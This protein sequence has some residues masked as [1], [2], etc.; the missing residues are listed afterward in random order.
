MSSGALE[1]LSGGSWMMRTGTVSSH[2]G[3]AAAGLDG[4]IYVA[5]NDNTWIYTVVSD[6]WLVSYTPATP[7][8]DTAVALGSDR[9]V[10]VIGGEDGVSYAVDL[11]DAWQPATSMWLP[12]APLT[13]A[14]T[15]SAAVTA[16][17]GRIY[18]IG[19][20]QLDVTTTNT[21]ECYTPELDHWVMIAPLAVKRVGAGAALGSDGRIYAIGGANPN[22]TPLRSVE[23]YG[24][25]ATLTPATAAASATVTLTGDNFAASAAVAITFDGTPVASGVT[26]DRGH[27]VTEILVPSVAAGAHTVIAIDSKSQYPTTITLN[28]Q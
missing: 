26:D 1:A 24:P 19:G 14:R 12:R 27:V 13:V 3:V 6:S 16:P 22:T 20:E 21:V 11:V 28:V 23:T 4:R 8:D 18:A 15:N 2:S 10:Y 25:R 9:V 7:R 5:D 17:D